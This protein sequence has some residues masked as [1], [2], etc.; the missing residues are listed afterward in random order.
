MHLIVCLFTIF[1]TWRWGD[2]Q[3]WR[4]YH[5]TMFYIAA[6]GLLYEYLTRGYTMW[7]FYPDLL[8][9]EKIT[10]IIYALVTMPLSVL[11]F[12]SRYP[13]TIR[14]QLIYLTKWVF[15]YAFVE[16]IL[17]SFGRISYQHGWNLFYSLLFDMMMFPMLIFHHKKPLWAYLVS[18]AIVVLLM[19]WFHVPLN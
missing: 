19:H 8:F 18:I 2:W 15:I 13:Q 14:K 5:P 9:N 12:L 6:G 11:I 16:T 10:V 1:A 4:K 17:H 7:F 3:N